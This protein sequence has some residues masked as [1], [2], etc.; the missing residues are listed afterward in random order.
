[1]HMGNRQE[2]IMTAKIGIGISTYNRLHRLKSLVDDIRRFTSSDFKLFVADD[3]STDGTQQWLDQNNIPYKSGVNRGVVYNKNKILHHFRNHDFIIIF[4]DDMC[5]KQKGWE[6][7][8]IQ[9][10]IQSG[11]NHL[12]WFNIYN[13]NDRCD[14]RRYGAVFLQDMDITSAQVQVFTRKCIDTV[15]GYDYRF[16]GYGHGHTQY[17]ERIYDA[18]LNSIKYGRIGLGDQYVAQV[19]EKTMRTDAKTAFDMNFFPFADSRYYQRAGVEPLY[20]PFSPCLDSFGLPTDGIGV[21]ILVHPQQTITA[22]MIIPKVHKSVNGKVFICVLPY[23]CDRLERI[24][25]SYSIDYIVSNSQHATFN[26]N[27]LL[28]TLHQMKHIVIIDCM[29]EIVDQDWLANAIAIHNESDNAAS[30]FKVADS[31]GEPVSLTLPT[32]TEGFKAVRQIRLPFTPISILSQDALRQL[33]GFSLRLFGYGSETEDYIKRA[34]F[35]D[36]P[37]GFISPEISEK[38]FVTQ[39]RATDTTSYQA[40][41]ADVHYR[42]GRYTAI[43]YELIEKGFSILI[44]QPILDPAWLDCNKTI[45]FCRF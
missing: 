13:K 10:L 44:N 33:G 30:F 19:L 7:V 3:G 21:G 45:E 24:L 37:V 16:L 26:K 39:V 28:S 20:S 12:S 22:E 31:C 5:I 14:V 6:S 17:T 41:V 15:G 42:N 2:K 23:H 34:R 32:M 40:P 4:E 9:S 1:M 25:S 27:L 35:I 8:F 43:A 18:G 11:E 29:I 38:F 36:L